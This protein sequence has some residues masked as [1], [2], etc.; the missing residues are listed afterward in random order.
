MKR[1]TRSM[2]ALVQAPPV[3][4]EIVKADVVEV[5]TNEALGY[6][7]DKAVVTKTWSITIGKEVRKAEAYWHG[8]KNLLWVAGYT[9]SSPEDDY[10]S[11]IHE[12]SEAESNSSTRKS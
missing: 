12:R 4:S 7:C 8:G 6:L 2:W 5:N 9:S 10:P 3:H 1:D 11:L